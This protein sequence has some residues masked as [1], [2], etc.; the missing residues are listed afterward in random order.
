MTDQSLSSALRAALSDIQ[1]ELAL[2]AR[3]A[4][5]SPASVRLIAVSKQQSPDAIRQAYALGVRDFGESFVQELVR[6]AEAL[7]DLPDLCFHMIGHLQKNKAKHVARVAD[8][9][10]S[11]DS[12]DLAQELGRR[13]AA[14]SESQ[15]RGCG[16]LRVLV[17]VNLARESQKAGCDPLELPR[18][19]EAVESVRGLQLRGLM[20]I[21]P[22][23]EDPE[24]AR[25]YFEQ[26]ATLA[27]QHGGHER[28]PELSMGMSQDF[29]VAVESGATMVRVGTHLFGSRAR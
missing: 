5:R 7:V 10:H 23:T 24:Q 28:L 3:R 27:T 15:G 22:A 11:V 19:L 26:L 9:V 17:Q 20:A 21:P 13:R 18:L 16:P 1:Q 2:A 8:Y 12:K 4:G 29:A 6:K 14:L 25:A